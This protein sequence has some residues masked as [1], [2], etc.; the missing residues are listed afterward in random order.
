MYMWDEFYK[1]N[2]SLKEIYLHKSSKI[3]LYLF[4]AKLKRITWS[5]RYCDLFKKLKRRY[6]D[7]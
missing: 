2:N 7:I 6:L 1:V 3:F 5:I 4:I